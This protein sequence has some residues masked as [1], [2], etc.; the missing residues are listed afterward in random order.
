M[1]SQMPS[2]SLSSGWD[3]LLQC[4]VPHSSSSA[5]DHLS[6]V[7]SSSVVTVGSSSSVSTLTPIPSASSSI[8]SLGSNGRSSCVS[9]CPSLSSSVSHRSIHPSPSKSSGTMCRSVT[10]ISDPIS[11]ALFPILS[12]PSMPSSPYELSPQHRTVPSS[13]IAHVK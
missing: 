2:P 12:V 1:A 13:I 10:D 7:S 8:Q 11:P 3:R 5:S 9:R 6:A 4:R